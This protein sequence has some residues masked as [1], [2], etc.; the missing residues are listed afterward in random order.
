[1]SLCVSDTDC[2]SSVVVLATVSRRNTS[3][4]PLVSPVSADCVENSDAAIRADRAGERANPIDVD[5]DA[6]TETILVVPPTRSRTNKS[7]MELLLSVA[8]RFDAVL[9]NK[10][11][12]AVGADHPVLACAVRDAAA[13]GHRGLGDRNWSSNT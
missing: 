3:D 12:A 11:V 7:D 13:V 8:T 2:A 4:W 1:M 6:L 10:H 5:P 9:A